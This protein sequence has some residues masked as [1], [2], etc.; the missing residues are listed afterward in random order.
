MVLEFHPLSD[1]QITLLTSRGCSCQDW[2]KLQVA[3]GFDANRVKN[4]NFSGRIPE[5]NV[6]TI[7]APV[8]V[9]NSNFASL[10]TTGYS[11]RTSRA[12]GAGT[13][14]V[15]WSVFVNP[16]PSGIGEV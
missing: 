6:F 7:V 5:D 1:G 15:P 4:T 16:V 3:A 13:G 11:L 9:V 10:C 2:S 14:I 8:G 12:A